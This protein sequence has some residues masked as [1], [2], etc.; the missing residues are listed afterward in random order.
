MKQLR[1]SNEATY[2]QHIKNPK[3][4]LNPLNLETPTYYRRKIRNFNTANI[5]GILEKC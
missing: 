5:N 4:E 2:V 3:Q 1:S